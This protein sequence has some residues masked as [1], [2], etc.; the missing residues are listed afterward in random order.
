MK[1]SEDQAVLYNSILFLKKFIDEQPV[2]FEA[3][4]T[5]I[6]HLNC[7]ETYAEKLHENAEQLRIS[8]EA[9]LSNCGMSG[10]PE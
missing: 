10:C 9:Q 6:G 7:I 1:F 2:Q 5:I 8:L 3:S 4:P